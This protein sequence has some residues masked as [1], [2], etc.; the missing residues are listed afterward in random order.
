LRFGFDCIFY[1]VRDLDRSVRFY[2]N[3]LGLDLQSR[4][5]VA[6]YLI[7]GMQLELVPTTDEK[8]LSGAGNARVCLGVAD[9]R[10]AVDTLRTNGVRIAEVQE[11]ENGHLAPFEDPDGNEL[12]L[13]QYH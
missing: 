12:V 9:I 13:W 4:D 8:V 3:V 7:D 11:V 6:R 5:V 2:S 10:E 1:Y